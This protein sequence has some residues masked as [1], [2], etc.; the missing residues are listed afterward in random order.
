QTSLHDALQIFVIFNAFRKINGQTIKNAYSGLNI[1][2]VKNSETGVKRYN[3]TR[4][5]RLSPKALIIIFITFP[6]YHSDKNTENQEKKIISRYKPMTMV[7]TTYAHLN[8]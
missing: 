2:P 1:E 3:C 7:I 6:M 8:I 4:K 5:L